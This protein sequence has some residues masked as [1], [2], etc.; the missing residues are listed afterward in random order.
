[1]DTGLCGIFI[2]INRLCPCLVLH[3]KVQCFLTVQPGTDGSILLSQRQL[4]RKMEMRKVW[5][6]FPKENP[7]LVFGFPPGCT[8]SLKHNP[9]EPLGNDVTTQE[10]SLAAPVPFTSTLN[11]AY[12]RPGLAHFAPVPLAFQRMHSIF[13]FLSPFL[14]SPFSLS[15]FNQTQVQIQALLVAGF[16]K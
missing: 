4:T 5:K 9:W 15:K 13:S 12:L 11:T 16:L 2:H 10:C 7:E 8:Q 3:P 14:L 1:M 6:P